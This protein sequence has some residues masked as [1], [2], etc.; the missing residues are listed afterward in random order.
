MKKTYRIDECLLVGGK[1]LPRGFYLNVSEASAEI[2]VP[3]DV[4][5]DTELLYTEEITLDQRIFRATY[6]NGLPV[7]AE[8]GEL[9]GN[10]V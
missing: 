1:L 2:I 5:G 3:S 6:E 8:D 4:P 9:I 7:Y 10:E